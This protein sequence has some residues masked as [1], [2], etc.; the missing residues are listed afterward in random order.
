LSGLLDIVR[1]NV[2][3]AL[4]DDQ[5]RE[6]TCEVEVTF[7]I[8]KPEIT[9][10]EPAIRRKSFSGFFRKIPVQPCPRRYTKCSA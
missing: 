10:S 8:E 5:R 4:R 2:F 1:L 7:L 6:P 3:A 9:G